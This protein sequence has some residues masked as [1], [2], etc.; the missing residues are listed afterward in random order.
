MHDEVIRQIT[1]E[2]LD[3][4]QQITLA[5]KE[6]KPNHIIIMYRNFLKQKKDEL[7]TMM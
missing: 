6:L 3:L 4:T 1:V 5:S 7:E 2:I